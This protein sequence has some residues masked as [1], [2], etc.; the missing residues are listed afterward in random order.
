MVELQ[1]HLGSQVPDLISPSRELIKQGRLIKLSSK[2]DEMHHRHLF[3]FNDM[4]LVCSERVMPLNK[5]K[6]RASL[7]VS[8]MFVLEGDHLDIEN[9]FYVRTRKRAIEFCAKTL[10]EKVEWMESLWRAIS[11]FTGPREAASRV[12]R[13]EIFQILAHTLFAIKR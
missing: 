3:L 2:S 10:K 12:S 7:R 9:A 5:Y 6:L 4:L 1:E 13:F 8:E 11:Q